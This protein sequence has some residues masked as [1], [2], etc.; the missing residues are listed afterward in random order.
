MLPSFDAPT[1]AGVDLSL[2]AVRRKPT[3]S[4]QCR[5]ARQLEILCVVRRSD[6]SGNCNGA[7]VGFSPK[8]GR[9]PTDLAFVNS[10]RRVYRLVIAAGIDANSGR[11]G[12]IDLCF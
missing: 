10:E 3:G 5:I 6:L 12:E 7:I 11:A 1:H 4:C 9:G 2:V 8:S